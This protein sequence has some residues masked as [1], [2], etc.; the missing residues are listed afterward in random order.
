MYQIAHESF[1]DSDIIMWRH[2]KRLRD[3]KPK[4]GEQYL[5]RKSKTDTE[6]LIYKGVDGKLVKTPASIISISGL[7][8][9]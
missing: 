6:Y 3:F 2:C 4:E 8:N 5:V 1:L 7:L 9:F